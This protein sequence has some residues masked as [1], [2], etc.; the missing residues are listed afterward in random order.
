MLD[1][2][3]SFALIARELRSQYIIAYEPTSK[4]SDG[5]FRKIEVRLPGKKDMNVRTR[6]GYTALERNKVI[7]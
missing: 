4:S 3:K 2:E 5:K 7:N 6:K 1:L